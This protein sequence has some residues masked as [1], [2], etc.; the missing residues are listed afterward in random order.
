MHWCIYSGD[1]RAGPDG[2]GGVLRVRLGC[3]ASPR[4]RRRAG[5]SSTSLVRGSHTSSGSN[6]ND[7]IGVVVETQNPVDTVAVYQCDARRVCIVVSVQ[8]ARVDEY[9]HPYR[10]S[11]MSSSS[12]STPELIRP[13]RIASF[14]ASES[15]TVESR[16]ESMTSSRDSW[17]SSISRVSSSCW[18][19]F[20]PVRRRISA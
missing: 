20:S 10:I 13:R 19:T 8:D 11:S 3:R 18:V 12:V 2:S 14:S 16:K 1:D 7:A 17:A 15:G 4:E 6:R 9:C 5:V